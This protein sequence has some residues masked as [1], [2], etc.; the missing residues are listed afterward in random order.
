ML[1]KG[2]LVCERLTALVALERSLPSV[3]PHV[4]ITRRS[5]SIVALV[6]LVRLFSLS[7]LS[8][9][10]NSQMSRPNARILAHCAYLRFFSRVRHLVALQVACIC[11]FVFTLIAIV[12]FSPSVRLDVPFEVG[13]IITRIVALIAFVQFFVGVLLD[14]C[15]EVGRPVA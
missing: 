14:V 7:V 8:H 3:H 10:V 2:S 12:Q 13:R 6:T 5:T 15:F 1:F 9:H 4:Q 11:C